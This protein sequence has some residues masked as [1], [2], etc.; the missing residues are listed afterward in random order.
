LYETTVV[1]SYVN[2]SWQYRPESIKIGQGFWIKSD[3]S[4]VLDFGEDYDIELPATADKSWHL[5]GAGKDMTISDSS[6]TVWTYEN[7]WNANPSVVKKGLGFWVKNAEESVPESLVVDFKEQREFSVGE[8]VSLSVE[9][10]SL[11]YE[12]VIDGFGSVDVHK[13]DKTLLF[14]VPY[15]DGGSHSITIKASDRSKE[16][17]FSV[18]QTVKIDNPKEYAVEKIDSLKE[19]LISVS[20]DFS[21]D[22]GYSSVMSELSDVDNLISQLS[23][24]ELQLLA[25]V[26]KNI[27]SEYSEAYS[28]NRDIVMC[29]GRGISLIART[30]VLL[31]VPKV[32]EMYKDYKESGNYFGK[33]TTAIYLSKAYQSAVG[34]NELYNNVKKDCS[35]PK[36]SYP[37]WNIID[38]F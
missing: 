31:G 19:D 38:E 29:V 16:L 28:R 11:S 7:G 30:A 21:S 6:R 27:D 4:Y 12:A 18:I 32:V 23:E 15:L 34:Y 25:Q 22:S 5:L 13:E 20:S 17:S 35:V 2:N 8:I 26:I 33:L 24:S 10:S 37:K 9:D 3:S 1:W 36:I 14:M